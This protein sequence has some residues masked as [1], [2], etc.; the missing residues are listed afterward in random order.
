MVHHSYIDQNKKMKVIY[1][2]A[3]HCRD[4]P[5]LCGSDA[6]LYEKIQKMNKNQ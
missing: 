1:E 5:D 4:N 2:Y 3:K 6:Y